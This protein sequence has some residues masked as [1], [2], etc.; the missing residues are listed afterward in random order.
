LYEKAEAGARKAKSVA[1]G[2]SWNWRGGKRKKGGAE[3]K[4]RVDARH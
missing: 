2:N 3:E 4:R 1:S